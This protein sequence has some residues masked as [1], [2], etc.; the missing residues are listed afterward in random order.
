MEGLLVVQDDGLILSDDLFAQVL[1]ARGQLAQF[2]QLADP[3]TN[4]CSLGHPN[5]HCC[6]GHVSPA[7]LPSLAPYLAASSSSRS[8]TKL[9]GT[10]RDST[11]SAI[12]SRTRR[13]F[14]S[15]VGKR[16]MRDIVPPNTGQDRSEA[17]SKQD[18]QRCAMEREV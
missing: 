14:P 3:E 11:L 10:V 4:M 13:W 18:G 17:W 12:C 1:P 5:S 2:L 16:Y 8:F 6:P 15:V 7:V 9:R